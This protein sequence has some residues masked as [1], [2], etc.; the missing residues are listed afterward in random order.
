LKLVNNDDFHDVEDGLIDDVDEI[1]YEKDE[2][3]LA[4]LIISLI[5]FVANL[6]HIINLPILNILIVNDQYFKFL[7]DSI[8]LMNRYYVFFPANGNNT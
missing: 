5:F 1:G 6:I 3:C 8:L 2:N 4:V 7:P